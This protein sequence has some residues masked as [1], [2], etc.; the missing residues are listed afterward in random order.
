MNSY[1]HFEAFLHIVHISDMHYRIDGTRDPRLEKR[2]QDMAVRLRRVS[3][4]LADTF[5]ELADLG[6][7]GHA[8]SADQALCD[9]L[10]WFAQDPDFGSIPAWLLDTGDLS[11]IGDL[12][13]LAAAQKRLADFGRRL[14]A[15]KTLS[16]YGNH[17]AWPGTFPML[18]TRA[19]LELHRDTLRQQY[20]PS[21]WPQGPLAIAIP[22]T[23]ARLLLH[24]V[25]SAYDDRWVNTFA[26]GRVIHDPFWLQR[27]GKGGNRQ[28]RVLA[29][30][31]VQDFP[32][33]GV[34]DFRVL[35]VH[36]PV[37]YPPPRPGQMMSMK[38]DGEVADALI[39]FGHQHGRGKLAALVLSGHT[40]ISFPALGDLPPDNGRQYY[41]PLGRGQLQLIAGSVAQAVRASARAGSAGG[42][43]PHQFQV[44]TFFASPKGTPQRLV[45]ERR[46]VGRPM[47]TG[48]FDFL[49]LPGTNSAVEAVWMEY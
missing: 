8:D 5:L 31:M 44:L 12:P 22:N 14:N 32:P 10:D 28:M 19:E 35:A 20:F 4:A 23:D 21:V 36:H 1:A 30:S 38:N 17:D 26:Q 45:M 47:G 39:R 15:G 6:Y 49:H 11:A 33:N 7:A 16:L 27:Q 2:L 9:F 43:L 46:L 37:Y 42:M 3:A 25:N 48:P 29:D 24:G 40:H 41:D 34:R 18:S 13:S